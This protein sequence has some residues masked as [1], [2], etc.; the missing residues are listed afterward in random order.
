MAKRF[1][2]KRIS[3]TAGTG[4]AGAVSSLQV[5]PTI[6]PS[7]PFTLRS[8]SIAPSPSLKF[9]QAAN[10]SS[11]IGLLD[12]F[13]FEVFGKNSFEQICIN[14]ANES[15][16]QQFNKYV[17]KNEQKLYE[18]EKIDW[19]FID[20]P[21]NQECLNLFENKVHGLLAKIDE[22][23]LFPNGND[24]D[25]YDKIYQ[26]GKSSKYLSISKME[27]IDGLFTIHHYPGDVTYDINTFEYINSCLLNLF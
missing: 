7:F 9:Q 24:N 4:G 26:Y 11:F 27:R 14:Y 15:L 21:D 18:K 10:S 1:W 13:G 2:S 3:G 23:C 22:Q 8:V 17:L 12:I 19:D 5:A 20:F 6:S 16:Q 25:L